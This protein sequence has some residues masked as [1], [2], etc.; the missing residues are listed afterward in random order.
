MPNLGDTIMNQN[1]KASKTRKKKYK[2][3]KLSGPLLDISYGNHP[4]QSIFQTSLI[5][6]FSSPTPC[7]PN[8]SYLTRIPQTSTYI[9]I[10]HQTLDRIHQP[11]GDDQ[12][13]A[14]ELRYQKARILPR[15][16]ARV[17]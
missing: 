13:S 8:D 15:Q 11:V 2:K 14:S 4:L 5:D 12:V 9:R 16:F 7:K 10:S 3:R 1:T 6:L 17:P